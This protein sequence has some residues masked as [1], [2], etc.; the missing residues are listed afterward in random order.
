MKQEKHSRK[1]LRMIAASLKMGVPIATLAFG[2]LGCE[3]KYPIVV[4]NAP[5]D[6]IAG[7]MSHYDYEESRNV[8]EID[9]MSLSDRIFTTPGMMYPPPWKIQ[10]A[11]YRVE[12]G[13]TWFT[14][15]KRF[16]KFAANNGL[17]PLEILLRIN[18]VPQ[19][20]TLDVVNGRKQ[21]VDSIP[22]EVGQII[23]VPVQA[24]KNP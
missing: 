18:N 17:K 1:V 7:K 11:R 2:N 23:Y 3:K 12:E 6:I 13:D 21:T 4:G 24:E 15:A 16:D 9:A 22:L 8:I 10:V 19:E 14:I 5:D 20:E